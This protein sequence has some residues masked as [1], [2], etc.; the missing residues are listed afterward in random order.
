[1]YLILVI[2]LILFIIFFCPESWEDWMEKQF[3]KIITTRP[4]YVGVVDVEKLRKEK[5]K[6]G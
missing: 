5:E 3:A 6:Y 4:K 2:A 1:M